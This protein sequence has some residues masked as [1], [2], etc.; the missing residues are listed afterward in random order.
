MSK[1]GAHSRCFQREKAVA[2]R[3]IDR[4]VNN[5]DSEINRLFEKVSKLELFAPSVVSELLLMELVDMLSKRLV[6]RAIQPGDETLKLGNALADYR[7][8]QWHLR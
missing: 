7:D 3:A 6:D 2:H 4:A 5:I 1:E 8:S